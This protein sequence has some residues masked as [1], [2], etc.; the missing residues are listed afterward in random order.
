[1]L[2]STGN[3]KGY[4]YVDKAEAIKP[5]AYGLD[6]SLITG[7]QSQ[8]KLLWLMVMIVE[9][10]IISKETNDNRRDGSNSKEKRS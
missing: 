2:H 1:M 5:Y 6:Y 4:R 9:D 3:Y 10:N 7:D 8:L